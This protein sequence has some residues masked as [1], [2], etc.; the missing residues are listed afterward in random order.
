ME[1]SV[2]DEDV[3]FMSQTWSFK[4]YASPGLVPEFRVI[5]VPMK[6]DVQGDVHN[7][8]T[9]MIWMAEKFVGDDDEQ[10]RRVR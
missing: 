3:V 4:T 6:D 2:C 7:K 8:F 1:K 10:D 5:E 9:M